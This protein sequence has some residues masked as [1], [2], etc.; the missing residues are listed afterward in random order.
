MMENA[1]S[2][3][4]LIRSALLAALA[5][6]SGLAFALD[7]E[8]S[9]GPDKL[10]VPDDSE[11]TVTLD[12]GAS[13]MSEADFDSTAGGTIESASFGAELGILIPVDDRARLLLTFGADVTEYDITPATGAVGTTAAT[14]G[15]QFDSVTE[16]GFDGLYSRAIDG[17]TSFFVGGGIGV[18]AEGGASDA[19]IWNGVG[20]V[21]FKVNDKLR[22]GMGVGVFSQIEDDVRVVPLPQVHYT[23]DDRWSIQSKG[24]GGKIEYKWNDELSMGVL[25][26]FDGRSF[27]IDGDNTLVPDGAVTMTGFPISYYLDYSGGET[28]NISFFAQVGVVVAGSMEI[29]NSTGTTVVDEDIDPGVFAGVGLKIEF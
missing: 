23:I 12:L 22:L 29:L 11:W 3:P 16:Y 15:T 13:F 2:A 4:F 19:V 28:S 27:R 26:Q 10:I 7:I 6:G 20:G 8:D 24:V 25:G 1:Q 17:D 18:A 9:G 5:G 14:V 21:S